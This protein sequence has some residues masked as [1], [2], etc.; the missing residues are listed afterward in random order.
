MISEY[1]F[2]CN[3]CE[4]TRLHKSVRIHYQIYLLIVKSVFTAISVLCVFHWKLSEF[5]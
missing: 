2:I 1:C 5:R 3:D 4:F